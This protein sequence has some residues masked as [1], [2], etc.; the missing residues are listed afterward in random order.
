VTPAL[1]PGP[2]FDR[3]RA[4]A[5][6]LGSRAA[7]LGDDCARLA[8]GPGTLA[9]ST[10]ASVEGVHFRLDWIGLREAG[11]RATAAALSDLAAA[12]AEP[13]GVLA[14]VVVPVAAGEAELVELMLGVGDAAAAAG[15]VVV[16]GDLA[17]AESG[18]TVAVT[19]LGWSA[20]VPG[21]AGALVGDG[22]WVTGVL[23]GAGAALE[24]WRRGEI[25]D[26]AARTAFAHPVPRI[27]AGRWLATHGARAMLDLSDGL[28]SDAA[29][30][31]AASAVALD[32]EL[33]LVPVH[34]AAIA[35]ARRLDQPVQQF[36]AEAGEDYE[37]LVAL[38]EE[39][40]E[41][42]A[43]AFEREC[44]VALTRIGRAARGHGVRARLAGRPLAL[45]GYDHFR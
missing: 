24:A 45:R 16:G 36:A 12:G 38:P 31:A 10:D 22:L 1:G 13:A 15:A 14:A 7:G 17:R 43:R 29:H 28:G 37:L 32:L 3:I 19:V 41:P 23:G 4:V 44:G 6:A 20:A 8:P 30:L 42:D 5:D 9:V 11:W 35:A 26:P 39:F 25:P 2:E 21:R 33:E 27:A 18:W 34:P 40:G